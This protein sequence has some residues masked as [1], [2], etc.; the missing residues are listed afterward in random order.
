MI[1][2]ASASAA[3]PQTGLVGGDRVQVGQSSSAI[4]ALSNACRLNL[5][6]ETVTTIIRRDNLLCVGGGGVNPVYWVV[7]G[8]LLML[9][10]IAATDDGGSTP[11]P[12]SP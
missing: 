6:S 2:G 7:G 8:G 10:V 11:R 9:G 12:V 3:R 5:Q 1:R 4:L